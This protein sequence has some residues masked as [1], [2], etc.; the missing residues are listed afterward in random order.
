MPGFGEQMRQVSLAFVPDCDPLAAGR[1]DP[2]PHAD[3]QPAGPAEGDPRDA[4]GRAATRKA[5]CVVPG[6]FAA[7]P[8]CLDLIGGPYVETNESVCKAFRPKSAQ[9]PPRDP[10]HRTGRHRARARVGHRLRRDGDLRAR[11]Y[12][13]GVDTATLLALRFGI[14]AL[15]LLGYARLS[16]RRAGRAVATSRCWSHWARAGYA[17]QAARFFTALTLAP[18]GLVALLLYLY[19]AMVALL[20]ALAPARAPAAAA[21]SPRS[22]SRSPARRSPSV[23]RSAARAARRPRASRSRSS[24]RRSTRSTSSRAPASRSGSSRS[25]CRRS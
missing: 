25:R 21:G 13:D 12:A 23:P 15:F 5:R 6:V 20:A 11:A 8:Y 10:A 9:R 18:A 19:P 4:R 3:P 2:R 14:A 22:S 16:R 24:P 7:V 17:G 1:R